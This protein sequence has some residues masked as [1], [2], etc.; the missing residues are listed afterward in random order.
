[1]HNEFTAIIER[2]DDWFIAYCAEIPEANG[3][4]RTS[5]EARANLAEAI[6]LILEDRREDALRRVPDSAVRETVVVE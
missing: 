4:G 2:D 6:A 5:A 1:M 3:Q